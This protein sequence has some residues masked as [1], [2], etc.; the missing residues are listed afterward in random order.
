VIKKMPENTQKNDNP[1]L[2]SG[3][4]I[5]G[6]AAAL[7][8]SIKGYTSI[9]MEKA[10]DF[11]EIG[12]G[13]QLGPNVHKMFIRLKIQDAI[14]NIAFYP[15]NILMNDGISGEPIL[16][17]DTGEKFINRFGAPYGVIH[18]ADLL[19]VLVDACKASDLITMH[20][21][22]T[23]INHEEAGSLITA[24]TEDGRKFE[25]SALIAADGIWS[26]FRSKIVEDG[27]PIISGHIAYR[28]VLPIKD[29]PE[30]VK[31]DDVVLWAGPK[32]HLVHYKLRRGELFNIVAVFHSD[33]YEE[34]WD[35]F[36]DPKEL[37]SRFKGARK[38]VRTLLEKITSWKM[39]VLCDREP[40]KIWS[41][42]LVALLGDA[43]HPTLQYMA[44]G[45]GMA[46]EDAVVLA[47]LLKKN[48]RNIEKTFTQYQAARYLRTG[49]VQATARLYGQ[50]YHASDVVAELRTQMFRDSNPQNY[51]GISWLYDGI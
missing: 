42:G 5:G 46:I 29:V 31:N 44:A 36:G 32:F 35:A 40:I 7:A 19:D 3:G 26:N 38:E 4:G 30:F 37:R 49:R 34:G 16:R 8:L 39:W 14:K 28:A 43:A 2:I 6:C 20:T 18:R 25:G 24:I 27:D 23:V 10:D 48:N 22:T 21:S 11:V 9:V 15:N 50:I 33:R 13:I 41:K 1:I 17:I 51:D 12:A 47:D 45:A